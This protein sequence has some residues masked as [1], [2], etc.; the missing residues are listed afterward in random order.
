MKTMNSQFNSLKS[1]GPALCLTVIIPL[2]IK[3]YM[4]RFA[5]IIHIWRD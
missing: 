3:R 4:L 5:R 2:F 1:A